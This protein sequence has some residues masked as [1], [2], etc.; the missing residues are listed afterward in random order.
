ML[1]V[2]RYDQKKRGV[3]LLHCFAVFVG[4]ALQGDHTEHAQKTTA[5]NKSPQVSPNFLSGN[6]SLWHHIM[7]YSVSNRL[8]KGE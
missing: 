2:Y 3:G 5:N 8:C 1:S 7:Q 4:G 6:F